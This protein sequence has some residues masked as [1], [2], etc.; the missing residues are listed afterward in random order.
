MTARVLLYLDGA[1]ATSVAF[2]HTLCPKYFLYLNVRSYLESNKADSFAQQCWRTL[3]QTLN[4]NGKR[5][6][7][8]LQ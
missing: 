1:S 4:T 3:V 5:S 6:F 7:S 2:Q 8:L